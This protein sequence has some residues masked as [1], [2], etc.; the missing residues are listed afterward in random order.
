MDAIHQ[1]FSMK[2]FISIILS[3]VLMACIFKMP[4]NAAVNIGTKFALVYNGQST[5]Y[6]PG[7]LIMLNANAIDEKGQY[8]Q[9]FL[10][11]E[12]VIRDPGF[13]YEEDDNTFLM[14]FFMP[15]CST[16]VVAEYGDS[17][18]VVT[19]NGESVS[20]DSITVE[21]VP[22]YAYI[23]QHFLSEDYA[24]LN[25]S[26]YPGSAEIITFDNPEYVNL[27]VNGDTINYVAGM[28]I[29]VR[30]PYIRDRATADPSIITGYLVNDVPVSGARTIY[31][32][33]SGE[34]YI[35]TI[36]PGIAEDSVVTAVTEPAC[37]V[38]LKDNFGN[39]F[40][41]EIVAVGNNVVF[42]LPTRQGDYELHDVQAT[43]ANESEV[44]VDRNDQTDGNTILSVNATT[45]TVTITFTWL[46][47]TKPEPIPVTIPPTQPTK[48]T[49]PVKRS[50]VAPS[51][52]FI[53]STGVIEI[54]GR[55]D[56]TTPKVLI[57]ADDIQ[58]NRDDIMKLEEMLSNK[59]GTGED[60]VYIF[61]NPVI[62]KPDGTQVTLN[63]YFM[64]R[65]SNIPKDNDSWLQIG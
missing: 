65:G 63:G 16:E 5:N 50:S 24:G 23:D 11:D 31:T 32:T 38:I 61:H 62:T 45:Q 42:A 8:F 27:T 53:R 46:E 55:D 51:T 30:E 60:A 54:Y 2:R 35:Q 28:P 25:Q 7:K 14:Y 19:T 13:Y 29:V 57:D 40:G 22:N 56:L 21:Q 4:S 17:S 64:Q 15:T 18:W 52:K 44:A 33:S 10:Y 9:G 47:V 49:P 26:L 58:K 41:K 39:H 1:S 36:L 20:T 43:D 59:N 48:I 6:A 12:N 3:V 34:T 37:T